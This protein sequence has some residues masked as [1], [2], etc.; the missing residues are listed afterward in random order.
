[1]T[2]TLK[3]SGMQPEKQTKAQLVDT[4]K[5]MQHRIKQLESIE[6]KHARTLKKLAEYKE[7]AKSKEMDSYLLKALMDNIPDAIYFK[8]TKSRFI[9][10]SKAHIK[11]WFKQSNPNEVVGKS[12]FDFFRLWCTIR[13]L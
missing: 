12:D 3:G 10:N 11:K 7:K 6:K 13:G 1:M 2:H 9:K 4:L 8:D 5:K